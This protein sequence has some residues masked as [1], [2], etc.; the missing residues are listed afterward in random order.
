MT[1][2]QRGLVRNDRRAV[3]GGSGEA[4]LKPNDLAQANIT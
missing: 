4:R 3:S 1:T 2:T